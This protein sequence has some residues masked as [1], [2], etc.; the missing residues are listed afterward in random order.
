MGNDKLPL[1]E[2]GKLQ[3]PDWLVSFVDHNPVLRLA[4]LQEDN[5]PHVTPVW[6]AFDGRVFY[7]ATDFDR[8]SGRS[9]RKV[10]CIKKNNK[11]AVVIDT[12][13]PEQWD[14]VRGAMFQGTAHFV[15][16]DSG[17]Y[18]HALELL[19]KKYPEYRGKYSDWLEGKGP[20][21][22][23]IVIRVVPFKFAFWSE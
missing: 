23:A 2:E 19:K 7:I 9:T 15:Q 20:E 16:E 10:D 22:K 13:N 6:F 8:K 12:Y 3:I 1:E 21:R 11:V 5:T 17:E 4:V 18:R 14:E